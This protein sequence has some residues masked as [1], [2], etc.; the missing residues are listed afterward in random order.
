MISGDAGNYPGYPAHHASL[1]HVSFH[2]SRGKFRNFHSFP[3]TTIPLYRKK[4]SGTNSTTKTTGHPTN[5]ASL[6]VSILRRQNETKSMDASQCVQRPWL[7]DGGEAESG[8]RVPLCG[9]LGS[10]RGNFLQGLV[11]GLRDLGLCGEKL[12]A[13]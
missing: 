6:F 3:R 2:M 5:V 13:V 8:C 4:R 1:P 10:I 7:R 12:T 9:V 11:H